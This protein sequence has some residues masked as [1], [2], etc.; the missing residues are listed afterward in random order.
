M[1]NSTSS[2]M[3]LSFYVDDVLLASNNLKILNEIKD[4]L[5]YQFEMKDMGEA[6]L[7]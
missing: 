1:K 6:S 5:K 2:F 7:C 4:W 3:I